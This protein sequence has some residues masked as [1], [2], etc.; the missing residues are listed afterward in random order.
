MKDEL[1]VPELNGFEQKTP[2]LFPTTIEGSDYDAI[3]VSCG[4]S[5]TALLLRDPLPK[6]KLIYSS[7]I[8]ISKIFS[9]ILKKMKAL[10]VSFASIHSKT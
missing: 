4:D 8:D 2:Y 10:N 3:E 9:G 6:L 1:G 7:E 5:H